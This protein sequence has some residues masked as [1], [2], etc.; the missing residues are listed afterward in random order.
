[1]PRNPI[2][3]VHGYSDQGESFKRWETALTGKGYDVATIHTCS[4]KTLTNEVTIKD[5]A[6]GFDRALRIRT[7]LDADQPFDAI[8]HSTGML[9]IRSWLTTYAK[10]RDRLKRLIGLAP[11]SFGSPLAHKGRSWLGA[12]FKGSK[13][14]GPDFLEA[15]DLVLDALELGSRFSWDLAH[16][17]LLGEETFYGPTKSTPYVFIFCGNE[18]Y[19][20]LRSLVNE[21]GTDGTVRW[22]GCALNTRKILLDLTRDPAR[23]DTAG[24]V[25]I[26]DWRNVNIPLLP[27]DGLN[28]G[29]ILND[30]S[31]ALIDMVDAALQ[32]SSEQG[33]DKWLQE[34]AQRTKKSLNK[35]NPW[36]QFIIRGVDE[37][38]DPIT[39]YNLE[40][41]TQTGSGRS[42]ALRQFDMDVHTY[43][44]DRSFRCFHVDLSKLKP[45]KL[46]NLRV[47][48]IASSG[49]RLVVYHGFGS[50]KDS[51]DLGVDSDGKW[52]ATLDIS[53]LL[54]DPKATLFWPFTTTLVEL[55]LNRE[56][57]PLS[58]K[59]D[60]CWF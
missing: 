40:L 16:L 38:G 39:D 9:V 1:M 53:G 32:V 14:W 46:D 6:E 42:R 18:S 36:Q 35:M 8:V 33:F 15:G 21:P 25:V 12:L 11:A 3:L 26:P 52:D 10:R 54:N 49:S 19:R 58:G 59:N 45:E 22:A 30:P 28:H 17:D 4:Y 55:K 41:F 47:R 31:D 56:P 37:R 13:E 29:S 48:V 51:P 2:V 43:S 7:G 34:A 44:A 27:V 5:I 60:V 50:E 57:F 24:R 23:L 20:G